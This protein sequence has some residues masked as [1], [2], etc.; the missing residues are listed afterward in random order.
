MST[1]RRHG[2]AS[3]NRASTIGT[4]VAITKNT[5]VRILIPE[6]YWNI[7]QSTKLNLSENPSSN[8]TIMV[9]SPTPKRVMIHKN[10]R[11]VAC[12]DICIC[13][14]H[15]LVTATLFSIS[16]NLISMDA[17]LIRDYVGNY[18]TVCFANVRPWC[19]QALSRGA[20]ECST[21]Y[22]PH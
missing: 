20:T 14:P 16:H 9:N 1:T 5:G 17:K 3:E 7:L 13:L 15:V 6:K 10:P 22:I 11:Q 4:W 2:L 18:Y 8:I 21:E 12:K 19:K